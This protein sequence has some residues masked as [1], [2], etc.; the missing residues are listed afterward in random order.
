MKNPDSGDGDKSKLEGAIAAI[1]TF[2]E[3]A[4]RDKL[5]VEISIVPFG[6]PG[7]SRCDNLFRVD[8]GSFSVDYNLIPS[9]ENKPKAAT[10]EEE[11]RELSRIQ[12]CAS[13]DLYA[14]LSEATKYL[15]NRYNRFLIDSDLKEDIPKPRLDIV[16]LSDGYD[17]TEEKRFAELKSQMQESPR[18]RVHTL[19]YG[20]SLGE[21]ARD[22]DCPVYQPDDRLTIGSVIQSCRQSGVE[23]GKLEPYLIDE[24]RLRDI[25]KATGGIYRLSADADAVA[26]SLKTVL[27]T[28]RQYELKYRQPG[29]DRASEHQT[30]VQIISPSLQL[31]LSSEQKY[32]RLKNFIYE[33]LPLPERL[34]ILVVT[35]IGFGVLVVLPFRW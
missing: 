16:L 28:L 12:P 9:Q 21:V 25:A 24:S 6:Y 30:R 5:P 13:T 15:R 33:S 18:V 20:E 7:R 1:K 29:A 35:V 34:F 22:F 26:Q 23:I 17:G 11:L 10:A 3:E 2:V 32:I 27:T 19:G 31:N 4:K 14:P 8:E